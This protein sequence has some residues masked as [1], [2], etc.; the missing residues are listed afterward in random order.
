MKLKIKYIILYPKN[1]ELEPRFISF[2]EDGVNIITGYSQRGKSAI[3]SIID[4]CMGSEHSNIPIGLIRNSVD[5]FAIYISVGEENIFLARDSKETSVMYFH[6]IKEK[7][8][9]TI[10]NTNDWLLQKAKYQTSR[11]NVV[12]FFESKSGFENI[13][14]KDNSFINSFDAPSSFR[15]T[16]AFLFQPQN[17]IANPTTMFFKTDTFE[18]L[19]RLKVLF[20]LV[21]G[22]KSFEIMKLEREISLQERIISDKE[23]KYEDLK[24]RYENWQSDIYEYY[25]EAIKLGLTNADINI[26]SSTV[27][28]ILDELNNIVEN[29]KNNKIVK[30]GASL[31]YSE[32]LEEL[33]LKRNIIL[34]KLD[35]ARIN[36]S[37]IERFDNSKDKYLKDT[38]VEVHERLKPIDW[39]IAQEGTSKCPF[40]DSVSDKALDELLSLKA[41]QEYNKKIVDQTKSIELSFEIEKIEIKK[42]MTKLE[43]RLLTIEKNIDILIQENSKYYENYKYIFEF[44]GKIEHI[45]ENIYK[46]SPSSFMIEEISRLKIELLKDKKKLS[47]LSKKFD[48]EDSLKKISDTIDKYKNILSIEDKQYKRVHLDPEKSANV[49]IED[50]RTNDMTFL[51]KIGSGANHMGYHL[52]TMFGLHE[53]FWKLSQSGKTNYI[54]S[55]LVIDQPSQVYFPEGFPDEDDKINKESNK[56]SKDIEDTK[57]IFEACSHFVKEVEF[58]TQV[59]VLEHAPASTW[60]GFEHMHLVEEWRGTKDD[61]KSDYKAL[62]PIDWEDESN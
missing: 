50:S 4:Y 6:V 62:I 41:H 46:L 31:R 29:I 34:R 36:L 19:K 3:I 9:N 38:I 60:Q 1:K 5:K 21:L 59:I 24:R 11:D 20:P 61:D 55:I 26:E 22:Y 2:Q 17:L 37:K 25:S 39:F 18:H 47:Q 13:P 48:K 57:M 14:Q 35:D 33:E 43:N 23:N 42:E 40:C 58:N 16:A 51:S 45:V 32:K 10:F 27:D 53:Y 7:G 8:E 49:K 30:L 54:P 15:D 56:V 28:Q 12:K 52:S 44:A